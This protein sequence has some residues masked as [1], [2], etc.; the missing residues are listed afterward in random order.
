MI[1]EGIDPGNRW[2]GV[3]VRD[4][5][6]LL[7]AVIVHRTSDGALPDRAYV[8]EVLDAVEELRLRWDVDRIAVEGVVEPHGRDPEGTAR[9]MAPA[10]IIGTALVAGAVLGRYP[11]ALLVPPGGNGS[12]PLRAYPS[13]LVGPGEVVGT[14]KRA[15]CRSAWDVAGHAARPSTLAAIVA[16]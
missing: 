8:D 9:I 4:R 10:G 7:A 16:R 14:G 13:S 5:Q 12:L 6:E 11:E 1:V 2:T 3:I 15:H